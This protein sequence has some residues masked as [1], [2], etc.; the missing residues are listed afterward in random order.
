MGARTGPF[1]LVSALVSSYAPASGISSV[2]H[3]TGWRCDSCPYARPSLAKVATHTNTLICKSYTGAP[4]QGWY[5]G[6]KGTL[7]A[8]FDQL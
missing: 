1:F 8:F 7:S 5:E 6:G 4:L 3:V 2:W